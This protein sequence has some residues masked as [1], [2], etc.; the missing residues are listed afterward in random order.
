[1]LLSWLRRWGNVCREPFVRL[2][3]WWVEGP[4]FRPGAGSR[5]LI[6]N[7]DPHGLPHCISGRSPNCG[8]CVCTHMCVVFGEFSEALQRLSLDGGFQFP[9]YP[10]SLLSQAFAA[11]ST[12]KGPVRKGGSS[13]FPKLQTEGGRWLFLVPIFSAWGRGCQSGRW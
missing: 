12:F 9:L 4:G 8:A 11:G 6:C 7:L 13:S 2:Q 1:M 3:S 10:F 5:G